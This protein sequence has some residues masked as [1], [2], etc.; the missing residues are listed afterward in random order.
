MRAICWQGKHH[1][2]VQKVPDP[3]ILNPRD[4]IVKVTSSGISGSD[5]HLYD[6]YISHMKKGD[7][8]GHEAMGEIIE[9]GPHVKRV[10]VG[11]RIVVPFNIACGQCLHCKNQEYAFCDNTNP[12]P[13]MADKMFG[14]SS[15]GLFGYSHLHG[16]YAGGQAEF[17]RVPLVDVNSIIIP[18]GLA[19]E[20]VLFLSDVAPTGYMAAE[21]GQIHPGDTVAIWGAGPVG[22]MALRS[23]YLFGADRVI[24]IDHFKS[25]LKIAARGGAHIIH[26]EEVYS[27]LDELSFLTGGRG[28]D[29][30][31]DAVG[32]EAQGHSLFANID[33]AKAAIGFPSD[34]LEVL[35]QSIQ[36]C[37]KGGTISIPG[38]YSGAFDRVPMGTAFNK[39]LTFKM[40]PTHTQ[41]YM[42]ILL[43]KIQKGEIDPSAFIT[44]RMTLDEGVA[45]YKIFSEAKE[46]CLK[47]VLTVH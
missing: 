39:G 45:A 21:N 42:P 46:E 35:H 30:C 44:H 6:G 7:I 34:Q 22:Q 17:L 10:K 43:E 31:I 2:S 11:D 32:L 18:P 38:I 4:A 37:K 27:L 1:V 23:A 25:R 14:H 41:K 9:I 33:R 26:Y 20:K 5:L 28:P 36:A 3:C 24:V 47:V 16:G 40:G 12:H 15:A 8:L 29:V 19:D 13:T